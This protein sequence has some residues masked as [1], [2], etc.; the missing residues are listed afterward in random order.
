[1]NGQQWAGDTPF[2]ALALSLLWVPPPDEYPTLCREFLAW[3][4]YVAALAHPLYGCAYHY[5]RAAGDGPVDGSAVVRG[6]PVGLTW[7]NVFGPPYVERL[8]VQRLLSAPAWLTEV[9]ADGAVAI[10]LGVHP[11]TIDPDSA[12]GVAAHVGLPLSI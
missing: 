10:T 3:A 11:D 12:N 8:G 9:L 6:E 5:W 7:L 4:T 1:M 2:D